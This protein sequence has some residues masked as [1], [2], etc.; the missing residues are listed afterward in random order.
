[1]PLIRLHM[2]GWPE[3]PEVAAFLLTPWVRLAGRPDVAE[4]GPP[5]LGTPASSL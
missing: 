4:I 2:R 1:M 3:P 5:D